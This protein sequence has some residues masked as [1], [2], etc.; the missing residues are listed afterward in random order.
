MQTKLFMKKS[1]LTILTSFPL[2]LLILSCKKD[3]SNETS[4]EP[5]I[6]NH[7]GFGNGN[8]PLIAVQRTSDI[9]FTNTSGYH[10][11]NGGYGS[12]IAVEPWP[13]T[14]SFI[15]LPH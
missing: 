11:Y 4:E 10:V 1:L 2:L 9:L 14:K 15:L 8:L 3:I 5:L 12:G 13:G 7:P 6:A